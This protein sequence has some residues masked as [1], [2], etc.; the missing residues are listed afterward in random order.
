MSEERNG[1]SGLLVLVVAGI[2]T[3]FLLGLFG[4]AWIFAFRATAIH[5]VPPNAQ[6]VQGAKNELRDEETAPVLSPGGSIAHDDITLTLENVKRGNF[7]VKSSGEHSTLEDHFVLTFSFDNK[8]SD[9]VVESARVG[10]QKGHDNAGNSLEQITGILLSDN[11]RESTKEIRPGAT[12]V[13]YMI[14]KPTVDSA[15]TFEGVLRW[16]TRSN[17]DY[18]LGRLKFNASDVTNFK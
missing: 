2:G 4:V 13:Y 3:F 17:G 16:K 10:L 9:I 14:L 18:H 7:G 12:G 8:S 1:P 6:F 15:S 5:V 11:G